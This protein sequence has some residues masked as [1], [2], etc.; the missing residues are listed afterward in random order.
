M[1]N[2]SPPRFTTITARSTVRCDESA[3]LPRTFVIRS[4]QLLVRLN[5]SKLVEPSITAT[6]SERATRSVVAREP[7]ERPADDDSP[8]ARRERRDAREQLEH[9]GEPLSEARP[10]LPA[11]DGHPRPRPVRVQRDRDRERPRVVGLRLRQLERDE[12]EERGGSGKPPPLPRPLEHRT[13]L[14][15]PE[16]E[17]PDRHVG[18]GTPR[19]ESRPHV[20]EQHRQERDP[21]PEH[22]VDECRGEVEERD[23][24]PE[25]RSGECEHEEPTENAPSTP[26]TGRES[27]MRLSAS[28]SARP[29]ACASRSGRRHSASSRTNETARTSVAPTKK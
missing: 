28:G 11:V 3:R 14:A 26:R 23:P 2:T 9:D 22:D 20:A 13:R 17:D 6:N 24:R 4:C 21:E 15:P 12:G 10:R 1:K 7:G 8:L 19:A 16:L 18:D 27:R 29:S 5:P 25:E